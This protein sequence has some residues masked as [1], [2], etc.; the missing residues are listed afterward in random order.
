[1]LTWAEIYID[2]LDNGK[3]SYS[4]YKQKRKN[5][6]IQVDTNWKKLHETI[7]GEELRFFKARFLDEENCYELKN[8]GP[9]PEKENIYF[10]VPGGLSV[11]FLGNMNC[12]SLNLEKS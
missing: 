1:M 5:T 12:H 11:R 2:F 9:I 4:L 6:K 8:T 7:K 10:R 3:I